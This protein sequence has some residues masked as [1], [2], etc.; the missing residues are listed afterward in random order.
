MELLRDQ[1]VDSLST[2]EER[3]VQAIEL[4]ARLRKE[5]DAA[6]AERDAARA[7]RDAV[8]REASSGRE[9]TAG[10]SREIDELREERKQIRGRIERLLDQIGAL[11]NV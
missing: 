8:L 2:L 10:L 7:E 6:L 11:N 3:I 4:V 9:Q 1:E 5:K